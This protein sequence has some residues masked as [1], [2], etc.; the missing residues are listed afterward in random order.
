MALSLCMPRGGHQETPSIPSPNLYPNCTLVLAWLS[1]E[2]W[3]IHSCFFHPNL[4]LS[5]LNWIPQYLDHLAIFLPTDL[6]TN[7]LLMIGLRRF[8]LL[9]SQ[10]ESQ[11][12]VGI[13]GMAAHQS[14]VKALD[15]HCDIHRWTWHYTHY[16]CLL[17][18][19]SAVFVWTLP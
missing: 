6:F 16:T 9:I 14:P 5:N 12:R 18:W 19:E 8:S 15:T 13:A 7:T 10:F 2:M 11:S 17:H 1:P 3:E 4:F